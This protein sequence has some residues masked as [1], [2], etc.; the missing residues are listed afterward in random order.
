MLWT[1]LKRL[2]IAI[3]VYIRVVSDLYQLVVRDLWCDGTLS[4]PVGPGRA[5]GVKRGTA[6]Y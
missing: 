6:I 1:L 3:R 2:K 4:Y 5:H